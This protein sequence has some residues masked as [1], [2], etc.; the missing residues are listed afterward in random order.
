MTAVAQS[1]QGIDHPLV[2]VRNHAEALELYRRMGFTPSPISY[3]PWGSVTSLMMFPSNFIELIGVDDPSKFGTN[4]VNGFCFGRQLGQFLDRGEEGVSLVALHSKDADADHARMVQAGLESQGRI[5]FR[6][7]MTLPDGRHDE[8]VVSLALFIDPELADAS[9]FI[10]HQHRP[11]LI[12]VKGWQHHPNGADG[13]LAITYLAD[14][15]ALEPRWR[16]LYGD[17]VKY[18]GTALE[19]DTGCGVLRAIDAA[20]AAQEFPGVE[21]P[22]VAQK[23]PHAIAIR[24]HT[25]SL[26]ALRSILE[27]NDMPH[28]EIPGRVFVEPQSAGNVI[29]EFVQNT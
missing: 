5:D 1:P 17:A 2:T 6:R 29:L 22:R 10:C 18:N 20:T 26:T 21:L 25:T 24:L 7:R 9:N 16:A 13:I 28:C 3:H 11:E 19:A 4:S 14:T 12:W 23:R 15:K 27:Q 8:A